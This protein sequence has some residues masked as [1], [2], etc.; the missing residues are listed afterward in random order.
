MKDRRLS[1]AFRA[2]DVARRWFGD[3]V[4][5]HYAALADHEWASFMAVVTEWE[6]ARYFEQT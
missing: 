1:P 3:D 6:T 4:V 5:D 2:S